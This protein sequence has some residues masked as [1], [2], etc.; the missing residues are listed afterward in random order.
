MAAAGALFAGT[1]SVVATFA[2]I[3]PM[4]IAWGVGYPT[5]LGIYSA[6]VDASEQGWV[7]GVATA[8]FTLSAGIV[9]LVGGS[10]MALDMHAPFVIV[11][12]SAVLTL[13]LAAVFWRG[14]ALQRLTARQEA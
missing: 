12:G 7:M 8:L 9:S 1:G 14:P 3:V 4:G 10:L 6:S 11:V 2:A 5:F 13:L